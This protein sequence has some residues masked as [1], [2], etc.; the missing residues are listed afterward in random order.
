MI[1]K[2]IQNISYI[3]IR[4]LAAVTKYC[5]PNNLGEAIRSFGSWGQR[6][7][8]ITA[9]RTWKRIMVHTMV[10]KKRENACVRGLSP[11]L[12]LFHWAS[13]SLNVTTCKAVLAP[14]IIF[15]DALWDTP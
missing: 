2:G 14:L 8:S 1:Q 10:A 3:C 7:Q 5:R 4:F 6:C 9:G 13:S 15:G 11:S 12:P